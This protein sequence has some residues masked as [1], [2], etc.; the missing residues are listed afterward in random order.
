LRRSL[1]G[2]PPV[3]LA[4]ALVLA[5]AGCG[6]EGATR[7]AGTERPR[8]GHGGSLSYAFPGGTTSLDPLAART[9]SA[10]TVVRQLFEPLV[11]KLQGPYERVRKR[12]GLAFEWQASD[13]RRVWSFRLR[14]RVRFHDGT[15]FNASAVVVNVVRWRAHVVAQGIL[16]ELLDADAPRPTLARII[17]R[18]PVPNLPSRLADPRLGLISPAALRQPG[19]TLS[20]AELR[21]AGSGPFELGPDQPLDGVALRRFRGWWG[22]RL[23]LGPALDR[24]EFDEVEDPDERVAL[25][26]SG[27]VRVAAGLGKAQADVVVSD[28]LVSVIGEGRDYIAVERS[29]RGITSPDPQPLSGV[30]LTVVGQ[31]G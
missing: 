1:P 22:S 9:P 14:P 3:A 25:L 13:D 2:I 27:A 15:P 11:A 6:G 7:F 18:E 17:L 21:L 5:A 19:E 24:I 20:D 31:G 8:A 28:P 23:G 10:I 26:R 16:P 29:V 30:W 4:L 12:R